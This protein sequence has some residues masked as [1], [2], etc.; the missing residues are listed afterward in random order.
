MIRIEAIGQLQRVI[1]GGR[2]AQLHSERV[3]DV[4]QQLNVC[5][6][7]LPGALADPQE[8]AGGAVRLPGPGV[9]PGQRMLVL[10]D[11]RLV[12]G[13]EVNGSEDV[14][15]NPA[16]HHEGERPIDLVGEVLVLHASC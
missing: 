1:G 4:P 13:V 9:D 15:V 8:V 11:Q 14:V 16:G 2:R 5:T 3:A 6:M 10:Q 7:Q 12:A